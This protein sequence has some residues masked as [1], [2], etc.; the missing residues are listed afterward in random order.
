M[1]LSGRTGPQT[2]AVA[3]ETFFELHK[4]ERALTGAEILKKRDGRAGTSAVGWSACPGWFGRC[5]PP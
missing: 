5:G 4:V 3:V 1:R 2:A